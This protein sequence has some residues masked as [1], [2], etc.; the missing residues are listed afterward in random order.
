MTRGDDMIKTA[1]ADIIGPAVSAEYPDGFL[2]EI[3]AS[4]QDIN[5]Q[6]VEVVASG[7]CDF[8][9]DELNDLACQTSFDFSP[10][11]IL[12][13]HPW[14]ASSSSFETPSS[15]ASRMRSA[16]FSRLWVTPSSMPNP[17]SALSSN[18]ELAQAGPC[19]SSFTV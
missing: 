10:S 13:S 1:I 16:S 5:E 12:S 17:Y 4:V 9:F 6:G 2:G 18:R 15:M 14:N 7:I 3:V 8:K 11:L 19:P